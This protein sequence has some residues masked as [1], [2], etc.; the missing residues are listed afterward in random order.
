MTANKK[1]FK[2]AIPQG[3]QQREPAK[4]PISQ[5]LPGKGSS[6]YF[7]NYCLRATFLIQQAVGA[8]CSLPQRLRKPVDPSSMFSLQPAPIIKLNQ[9][10]LTGRSYIHIRCPSFCGFHLRDK[11][12]DPQALIAN[13]SC[14][15]ES[16]NIIANKETRVKHRSIPFFMAMHI[17]SAERE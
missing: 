7:K 12:L 4:L 11:S 8:G 3:L 6:V 5:A 9:Q 13:R 16:H 14:I 1:N 10:Y 2:E 17:G 15:H